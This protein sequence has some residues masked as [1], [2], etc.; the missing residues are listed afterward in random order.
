MKRRRAT[1]TWRRMNRTWHYRWFSLQSKVH[2]IKYRLE[3]RFPRL[4]NEGE[5]TARVVNMAFGG[6]PMAKD[7]QS[8][9]EA[10]HLLQA[11]W[12][13]VDNWGDGRRINVEWARGGVN[14][15]EWARAFEEKEGA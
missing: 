13:I 12:D 11:I 15:Y 9:E 4:V 14:V 3:R 5:A 2:R 10:V 6:Y 1:R 7:F 8:K